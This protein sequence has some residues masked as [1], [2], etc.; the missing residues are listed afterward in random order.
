MNLNKQLLQHSEEIPNS[1]SAAYGDIRGLYNSM[2]FV[3][4]LHPDVQ[5]VLENRPT[6]IVNAGDIDFRAVQAFSTY[7]HETVHWW[8]HIGSTSGPV[9]SLQYPA[10]AH[11]NSTQLERVLSRVGPRKSLKTWAGS[12]AR[13]GMTIRN[14]GLRA[15]NIAVNN[16]LDAEF[17]KLVT[18]IPRSI[19]ELAPDPYFETVGHSYWMAY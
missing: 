6:G 2:Q 10:Q 8:Q 11:Q 5:A 7:L 4:R 16:A 12:A 17:Y 19:P 13:N 3:L 1:V 9:L 14:K 18:L 15:A